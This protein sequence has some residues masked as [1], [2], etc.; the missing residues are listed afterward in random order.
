[1]ENLRSPVSRQI[2]WRSRGVTTK[3]SKGSKLRRSRTIDP[4][5]KGRWIYTWILVSGFRGWK[6]RK[7]C[8]GNRDIPNREVSKAKR[9]VWDHRSQRGGQVARYFG[10]SESEVPKT[11]QLDSRYCEVRSPDGVK[12]R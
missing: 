10:V 7:P 9:M 1:V 5:H 8:N 6:S 2:S 11:L 12:G 4:S 3:A